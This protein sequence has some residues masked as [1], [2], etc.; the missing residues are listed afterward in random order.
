MVSA[1]GTMRRRGFSEEAATAALVAQNST[2]EG[3]P[4]P[5][6]DEEIADLVADVYER[7]EANETLDVARAEPVDPQPLDDVLKVFRR[8]LYMPDP[9]PV[10]RHAR[11]S[12]PTV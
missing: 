5:D 2:Y 8:W 1:A 12:R 4:P 9:A 10:L 7:Y 6:S 3:T 11:R